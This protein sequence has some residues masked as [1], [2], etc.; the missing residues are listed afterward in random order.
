[1]DKSLAKEQRQNKNQN[2]Q[3]PPQLSAETLAALSKKL[4][5][6]NLPE[7]SP[8][9]TRHRQHNDNETDNG[10]K[11]KNKL[12]QSKNEKSSTRPNSPLKLNPKNAE[13]SPSS[14]NQDKDLKTPN[15]PIH[16]TPFISNVISQSETFPNNPLT[17]GN[18][19]SEAFPANTPSQEVLASHKVP[20][21]IL[22]GSDWR[23]IAGKLM[24]IVPDNA[25]TAKSYNATSVKVQCIDMDTYRITQKHFNQHSIE[26]HSFTL[27]HDRTLKVVIKGLLSDISA[28]EVADEL[29]N[30]GYEPKYVRQFGTPL[31]K[32]PIHMVTLPSNHINKSI[33]NLHSLFYMTVKVESYKSDN[34]AQ[35]Y[36]CQRFGHSSLHCNQAP[37]CVKCA[38]PHQAKD[39]TKKMEEDPT[40]ANCKG[41]HTANFKRCPTLL[42][43]KADKRPIKPNSSHQPTTQLTP[44]IPENILPIQTVSA[45]SKPSY[46]NQAKKNSKSQETSKLIESLN[47]LLKKLTSDEIDLKNAFI[48]ILAILPQLITRNE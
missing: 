41:V 30:L 36:A 4:N 17:I 42:Q 12:H 2:R 10:K 43:L 27:S 40:C 38:G 31:K 19:Q 8:P 35:C 39:C 23:K 9:T 6:K 7:Y 47:D 3:S 20:P 18:S 13:S 16:Q 48:S 34:P 22:L 21:F 32:M 5:A 1:M 28:E 45:C 46:A 29:K 44:Q 25:V 14:K 33:F 37:R 11:A 26:F 15:L 24:T